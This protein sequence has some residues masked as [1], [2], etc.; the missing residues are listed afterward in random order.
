MLDRGPFGDGGRRRAAVLVAAAAG[1]AAGLALAI[2]GASPILAIL[3][4]ATAG[5]AAFAWPVR[6]ESLPASDQAEPPPRPAPSSGRADA[7][8]DG[9]GLTYVVVDA[10]L[11]VTRASPGAVSLF[12]SLMVGRPVA[13]AIRD[14]DV[15]AAIEAASEG[16]EELQV[17]YEERSAV[18]RSWRVRV[19]RS[20]EGAD[21]VTAILLE[22]LTEQK[23]IER[24]RVDF[25]ANASHE[26]RTPLASLLGFIETLQGPARHDANARMRFLG[27]MRD[28]A[29]RMARLIDDLLSLSRAELRAHQKPVGAVDLASVAAEIRDS[30]S[31]SAR[32]RG[33]EIVLSSPGRP[34]L[35]RG[36]RDDL[37]RVAE[38]LIENAVKYGASGKRVEVSVSAE[39]APRLDVRDHGPG[40]ASAHLP[41]LT[42]RFYRVDVSHSREV[43]GTGL[44]LA[45]VKHIVARHG[46]RLD[47]ASK[48]G[49]GACFSV[50]FPGTS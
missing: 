42:E 5:L 48:P 23:A 9:F 28:Q 29:N 26:L 17:T 44:G 33:V 34:V 35:V 50:L 11:S 47:V 10:S 43:G 21:A 41:R 8:L 4:A 32:E 14:P 19:R 2:G 20:G 27:I 45:I 3:P 46:A 12:P 40:I 31:V 25:V 16:G 1:V 37:L 7:I 38:N 22:D 18:V 13:F 36:D 49:E 15:L 39:P 6:P 30:L 24:L